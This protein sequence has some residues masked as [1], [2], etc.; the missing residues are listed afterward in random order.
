MSGFWSWFIIFIVAVN[1][2][3]CVWLLWRTSRR[4]AGEAETTGHVWDGDI[5]EYNKPL[6]RWWLNL[7]YATIVF[8]LGYLVW[9]P[10]LGAFA[11]IGGWTSV[12][13]HDAERQQNEQRLAPMFERFAGVEL[14]A[15][16]GDAEAMRLGRSIFA[17]NCA[18]CHGSDAR[19]AVGFPNLANDRWQWGGAPETILATVLDGRQGVMPPFGEALGSDLAI[20][21][22][23]IYV[24]S[25]SG[26]K[27]SPGMAAVGKRRFDMICIACHGVEGTGN[28]ALGAPDLTDAEWI[29]G[30]NVDAI[31]EAIVKGRHG[32]MP[33]HRDILGEARARLVAAWIWSLSQDEASAQTATTAAP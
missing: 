17:N 24:Q 8:S 28:P 25:L 7:F 23:A 22:T 9:Y 11:G 2:V 16:A 13:Q 12:G 33:A 15:L 27:V 10:G 32:Q 31:R 6:P 19:G 14:A 26:Q 20:T 3:G 18:M 29:Y 5:T 4:R 21:E 30:G 1:I